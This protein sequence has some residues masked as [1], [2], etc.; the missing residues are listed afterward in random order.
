LFY[1][2]YGL[3]RDTDSVAQRRLGHGTMS[4][5]QLTHAVRYRR[6]TNHYLD[7]YT[8]KENPDGVFRQLADHQARKNAVEENVAAVDKE[9]NSE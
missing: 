3:P 9:I 8:I 7:R 2:N 4:I 5:P 6:S 1:R